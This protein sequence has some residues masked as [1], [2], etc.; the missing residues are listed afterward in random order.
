[1][2]YK[3]IDYSFFG[4]IVLLYLGKENIDD[5]TGEDWNNLVSDSYEPVDQQYVIDWF[6]RL[7]Y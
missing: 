4:N 1:M 7:H 6:I 3:I 2:R 5:W